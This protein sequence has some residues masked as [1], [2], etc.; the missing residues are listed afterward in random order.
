MR[1]YLAGSEALHYSPPP[2]WTAKFR[3]S[4]V[5]G[6]ERWRLRAC[7]VMQR[8]PTACISPAK[9]SPRK[10]AR[11]RFTRRHANDEKASS[12][13]TGKASQRTAPAFDAP[14]QRKTCLDR[15]A[16]ELG[17]VFDESRV[18]VPIAWRTGPRSP[19]VGRMM[20][21]R[22]QDSRRSAEGVEASL[23]NPRVARSPMICC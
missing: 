8:L 4:N 9:K 16:R 22:A 2:W 21:E 20:P 1:S 6:Q 5:F 17:V 11:I 23:D 15:A 3:V 7:N 13:E 18:W 19:W 14:E 12:P 10:R